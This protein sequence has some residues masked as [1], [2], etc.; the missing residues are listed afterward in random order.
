M[1]RIGLVKHVAFV[2]AAVALILG[3]PF[4]TTEYVQGWISGDVDTVSS[5]S[6]I[7][8]QPSGTYLVL[9]N[10]EYH[11]DSEKVEDWITFFTGGEITYI[12]EDI[13]CSVANGDTGALD[14]AKSFQSQLPENQMAVQT[15]DQT[16][17]LSRLDNGKYDIIIM[18][19]E[20]AE[21]NYSSFSFGDSD[22]VIQ[23]EGGN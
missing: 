19:I 1:K 14:L 15:V 6:V 23:M 12:F 11:T 21:A 7:L 22:E 16:L 17:L 5:A 18:S 9:I 20:F 10:R 8:D 13:S 3:V 4:A 2:V